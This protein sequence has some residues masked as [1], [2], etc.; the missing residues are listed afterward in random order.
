MILAARSHIRSFWGTA[1]IC[2][3]QAGGADR[4]AQ[5]PLPR[6]KERTEQHVKSLSAG[7][8]NVTSAA[9]RIQSVSGA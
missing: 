4:E 1:M 2:V 9:H 3:S 5:Q 6:R 7:E 8:A